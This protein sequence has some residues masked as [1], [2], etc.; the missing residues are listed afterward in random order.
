MGKLTNV[1]G[2]LRAYLN[3]LVL[4]DESP[5]CCCPCSNFHEE[6]NYAY[7]ENTGNL[8]VPCTFNYTRGEETINIP[9]EIPLPVVVALFGSVND[10]LVL[11]GQVIEPGKYPFQNFPCNGAHELCYFF[12][13]NNRSFTLATRDN[14]GFGM[15]AEIT[16]RFCK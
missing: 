2:K 5:C 7:N 11:D 9:A 13:A 4:S 3:K 1:N 10:D 8:G 15:G 6:Q 16:I 14:F 12:T